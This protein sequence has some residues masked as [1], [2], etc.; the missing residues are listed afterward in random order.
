LQ[1]T[2]SCALIIQLF[3]EE[4]LLAPR[5]YGG[6]LQTDKWIPAFAGMTAGGKA[7][8]LSAVIPAKA[9]IHPAR[10]YESDEA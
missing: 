5:A 10:R 3:R 8:A 7:C 4:V 2:Y 9:G 6:E 1:T